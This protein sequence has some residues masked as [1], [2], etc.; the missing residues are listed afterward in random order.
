[1]ETSLRKVPR[2]YAQPDITEYAGRTVDNNLEK[3]DFIPHSHV[4]LWYNV[5]TD[6]YPLHHHSAMEIIY[7]LENPYLV[8]IGDKTFTL[9][10]GDIC[11]IPPHALHELRPVGDG[12]RF[13][14]LVEVELLRDFEDFQMISPL[15]R[16]GFI[17]NRTSMPDI[18]DEVTECFREMADIYFSGKMLWESGVYIHLLTILNRIGREYLRLQVHAKGTSEHAARADYETLASL[19]SYMETHYNEDLT[20][21]Q[22]ADIS[23]FS[24]Y[25]FTRLFKQVTNM[26]FCDYLAKKRISAAQAMLSGDMAITDI[27]F[28]TGFNNL[29]TFNR[30]F[31]KLT[32]CS[33]TEYRSRI[34]HF[35]EIY[36]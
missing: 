36:Y 35:N 8:S 18:Y 29:T 10:A 20:L 19:L 21:E 27:A 14:C 11:F 32:G 26:T 30:S 12:A 23:G 31:K 28:K 6:A 16:D 17:F 3:V 2:R 22:A 34:Q 5:Q 1:M 15:F 4:R 7:C 9:N 33:P 24:K 25:Y 13:I